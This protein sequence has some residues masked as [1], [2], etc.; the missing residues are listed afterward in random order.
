MQRAIL[1]RLCI[2]NRKKRGIVYI[3]R[4]CI[5]RQ[6]FGFRRVSQ[7]IDPIL[8]DWPYRPDEVTVR[9]ID[10]DE[11]RRKIQLRLDLGVLQLEIDGRPDGRRIHDCDSWFE[12]HQRRQREH[13]AAHPDD[14]PYLLEPEDCAELLREGVQ[15]YHRYIC[16]WHLQRYEL[17]ARDT[18]RNLRLFA[19]VREHAR[20]DRD[21]LQFDQWRPYVTMMHARA[22][23]TP[24]VELEQWDAAAGVLDA[25]IRGIERFLEDYDQ[26][27]KAQQVGELQFL[28]QWKEEIVSRIE[29][30]GDTEAETR[31][32]APTAITDRAAELRSKLK[33]AIIEERYEDAARLRDE[34]DHLK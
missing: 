24:L 1:P 4:D 32:A 21:K 18:L 23:A 28:R 26:S 22:V 8:R 13:D 29:S 16:F 31:T 34:I 30:P 6:P 27:E 15:Y 14:A 12:Y 3:A 11:G 20:N 25:G 5:P 7:D 2:L 33:R 10:G 9:L 17:C 19:F